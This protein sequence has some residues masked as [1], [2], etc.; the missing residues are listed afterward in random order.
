M[1]AQESV[2]KAVLASLVSKDKR[3]TAYGIFYAVFGGAW[4]IG[5][6]VVGALYEVNVTAL[7]LF[8]S[9]SQLISM[10]IL[11]VYHQYEVKKAIN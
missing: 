9:L 11:I 10:I 1:G 2:L 3:A 6:L 8:T 5:S 4:F 7:V